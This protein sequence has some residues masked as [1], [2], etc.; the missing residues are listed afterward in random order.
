[1][2]VIVERTELLALTASVRSAMVS[3]LNVSLNLF[4]SRKCTVGFLINKLYTMNCLECAFMHVALKCNCVDIACDGTP[5][6]DFLNANNID[7]F[8]N[9]TI[10]TGGLKILAS[11]LTGYLTISVMLMKIDYKYKILQRRYCSC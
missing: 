8:S 5:A 7:N 4:M 10:V 2:S 9:C 1:M 3:V 6:G 11:T